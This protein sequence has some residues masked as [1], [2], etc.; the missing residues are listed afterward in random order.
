MKFSFKIVYFYT[1]FFPLF[2]IFNSSLLAQYQSR[3]IPIDGTIAAGGNLIHT[4][5]DGFLMQFHSYTGD[6]FHSG[7]GIIKTDFE[8]NLIWSTHID[9]LWCANEK[10]TIFEDNGVIVT[11]GD[12]QIEEKENNIQILKIDVTSGNTL[13]VIDYGADWLGERCLGLFDYMGGYIM[14]MTI[15]V[16]DD[17]SYRYPVIVRFDEDFNVIWEKELEE[18]EYAVY[19]IQNIWYDQEGNIYYAGRDGYSL[20]NHTIVGK[21][22]ASGDEV[23]HYKHPIRN[24]QIS[25]GEGLM[26]KNEDALLIF[27]RTDDE[28]S[29]WEYFSYVPSVMKI[30]FAGE[31]LSENFIQNVDVKYH[32][33][34]FEKENSEYIITGRGRDLDEYSFHKSEGWIVAHN[35]EN[36]RLWQRIIIDQ[37]FS[38]LDN[39]IVGNPLITGT[40]LS[41]GT[42]VFIGLITT[43]GTNP[44][45]SGKFWFVHT[46][47]VGC[48]EPNCGYLQIIDENGNYST[49]TAVEDIQK[50]PKNPH[51]VRINPN[52]ASDQ[53]NISLLGEHPEIN[54]LELINAEGQLLKV[55]KEQGFTSN[56]RLDIP[57]TASGVCYIRAFTEA[58]IWTKKVVIVP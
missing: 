27:N 35:F 58:G 20:F 38:P 3:I 8:G 56:I 30:N 26:L 37:R 13:E 7:M 6:D 2:L 51:S 49:T 4:V 24:E 41:D 48:L 50:N 53:V 55:Y 23:W 12:N 14:S 40:E 10:H 43:D 47:S 9:S 52:P 11:A 17:Q 42:M 21:M 28:T 54:Q 44:Q 57:L 39:N 5:E 45:Y 46:D 32:A 15:P 33:G 16:D 22:T 25:G 19:R 34:I 1:F 18:P 29:P 31:L 36:E